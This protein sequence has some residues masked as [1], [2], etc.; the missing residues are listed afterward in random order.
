[1][2]VGILVTMV[3]LPNMAL[4]SGQENLRRVNKV[5]NAIVKVCR[6]YSN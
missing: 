5:N 6:Y 1:M 2:V 3:T 4:G